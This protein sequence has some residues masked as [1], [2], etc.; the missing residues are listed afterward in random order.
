MTIGIGVLATSD[1]GRREKRTPDTVVL[2]ADTM[3]SYQDVDSHARLH[4]VLMFPDENLFA[5]TAGD[6]SRA[7][8][9][10][11]CICTFLREV[12]KGQKT[13]GKIQVAI[14]E[15]CFH[16]KHHLFTLLELPRMRLPPH[17]F[18]PNQK[19]DPELNEKMQVEWAKF[20][21]GCDLVISAFDDGGKAYLFEA[22]AQ[23][24]SVHHRSFP[25]FAAIG[26]G[27]DNAMFWLSRR[28]H[29]L[30][31]L[32]LR[33][34]YHAYEAK[35]TS[36]S[37]AHVNEH[38]DMVIA[39]STDHW[40]CT[41]HKSLHGEKEHPEVNISNLKNLLKRYWVKNTDAIGMVTRA[42]GPA[43]KDVKG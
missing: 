28:T 32:P 12:P 40:F 30:G 43:F 23:Q 27:G 10:L 29:T 13:F 20:D 33:A 8:Q 31:L 18:N 35:L 26:S 2:L 36:E 19:L 42:D 22:N 34:A 1:S 7:A 17:A 25:G 24:H 41:T 9:S 37:S 6:V 39:P 3:G 21:F 4:K 5:A 38:L 15:G 16:Y 14:A 11:P